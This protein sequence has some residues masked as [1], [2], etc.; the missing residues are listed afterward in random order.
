VYP[1][2]QLRISPG[3]SGSSACAIPAPNAKATSADPA[4]MIARLRIAF[5]SIYRP[6]PTLRL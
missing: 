1:Q 6:W 2:G 5:T 4:A 3:S